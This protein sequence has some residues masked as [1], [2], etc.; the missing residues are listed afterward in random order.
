MHSQFLRS[1]TSFIVNDR[2]SRLLITSKP[3]PINLFLTPPNVL[4]YPQPYVDTKNKTSQ[5]A[6]KA[7]QK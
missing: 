6:T 1:N 2:Q 7:L 3:V 5:A 4:T